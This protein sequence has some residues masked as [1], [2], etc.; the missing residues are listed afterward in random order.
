MPTWGIASAPLIV[1]DKIVL[2]I[3]GKD[4]ACIVALDKKTGKEIWRNLED[5]AS[6]SAPILIEQATKPVIVVWTARH[7]AGL[8]PATGAVYWS[9]EFR[10]DQGAINIASPVF[11]DPYL[12]VSSFWDGSM[13]IK[14]EASS[15]KA[16]VVWKRKGKDERHTDALHCC[17]STPLIKGQYIFGVDS[18]GEL[19]CLELITGNRVWEN[20]TAVKPDRWANIHL[21][22]NHELTYMFNERGELIIALLSGTEFTELSRARLIEPTLSQLNRS[23]QG[24]TWAHPAFANKHV[25]IRSDAELVC[26]DLTAR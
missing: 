3:G 2:Q 19:R 23:G 20:L 21:I 11:S 7:V 4:N 9:L 22:Q 17:I 5:D 26:A 8:D 15:L 18:Y 14:L 16:R 12:F 24:V 1:G 25:F 6:Y 13:L 10:Q